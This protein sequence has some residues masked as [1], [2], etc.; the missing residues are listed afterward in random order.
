MIAPMD[1]KQSVVVITGGDSGLGKALV[2]V[3]R[4]AGANVFACSNRKSDQIS[5]VDVTDERAVKKF[6]SGVYSKYNRIDIVINNAGYCHPLNSLEDIDFNQFKKCI[7]TNIGGVF[8]VIKETLP[9]MTKQ[10]SGII[11]NIASGAALRAH[12][13]LPVYSA[14]KA[15]VLSLTQAVARDLQERKSKVVCLAVSPGGIN[16]AMR[17]NLFGEKDSQAQQAPGAV[18]N[19][20]LDLASGRAQVKSGDNVI[21]RNGKIVD[22]I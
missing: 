4:F 7:D 17:A 14:S 19:L 15:A 5:L 11:I 12:P 3:F 16:T 8:N 6:I 1:I 9:I 10:N 2:D 13:K 18:A 22:V 20:I 21:I